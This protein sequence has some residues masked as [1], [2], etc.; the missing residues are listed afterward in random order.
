M[1]ILVIGPSREVED[2]GTR[3]SQ[4]LPEDVKL[5]KAIYTGRESYPCYTG[6]GQL[7]EIASLGQKIEGG[8]CESL[9]YTVNALSLIHI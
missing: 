6:L 7:H 4:C 9:N 1:Y 2:F 3:L 8:Y 5:Q